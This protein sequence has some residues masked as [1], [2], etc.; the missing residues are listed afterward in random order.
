MKSRREFWCHK[1]SCV[2]IQKLQDAGGKRSLIHILR[3]PNH[4]QLKP[5]IALGEGHSCASPHVRCHCREVFRATANPDIYSHLLDDPPGPTLRPII[6][7]IW[8]PFWHLVWAFLIWGLRFPWPALPS[9]ERLANTY[10]SPRETL[11][12]GLLHVL[13]TSVRALMWP[14]DHPMLRPVSK[15]PCE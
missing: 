15:R 6:W 8:Q 7:Q 12:E 5:G 13:N 2:W 3:G 9:Q 4:A 1:K 10:G 11:A 14:L